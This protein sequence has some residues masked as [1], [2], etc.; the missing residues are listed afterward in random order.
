MTTLTQWLLLAG[1]PQI[2]LSG[3]VLVG[4][5]VGFLTSGLFLMVY[6]MVR[7]VQGRHD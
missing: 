3:L 4:L 2:A 1:I 7:H 6:R 5:I